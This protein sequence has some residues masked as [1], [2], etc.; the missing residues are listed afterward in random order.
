MRGVRAASLAL[1][2]VAGCRP[3]AGSS[4]DPVWTRVESMLVPRVSG[5]YRI[6]EVGE[7]PEPSLGTFVRYAVPDSLPQR[8]PP[9]DLF[10]Y[11]VGHRDIGAEAAA[12]RAELRLMDQSRPGV[13]ASIGE[14]D[15]ILTLNV[16]H[17]VV[18]TVVT[19]AVDT[20][21]IRSFLYLTRIDNR[22]LKF[23]VTYRDDWPAAAD[24]SMERRVERIVED[25]VRRRAE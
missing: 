4:A 19:G 14:T 8:Y 10:V 11:P 18:R 3:P 22:F 15:T 25:V 12:A 20:V 16:Q 1:V 5:P 13:R 6:V 2:L 7:Y 9:F 21:S 24:R 23:R 17:P